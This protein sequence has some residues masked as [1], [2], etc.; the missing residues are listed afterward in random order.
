MRTQQSH[1]LG[2]RKQSKLIVMDNNNNNYVNNNILAIDNHGA[3][4]S[5][6]TLS[7]QKKKKSNYLF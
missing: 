5:F 7:M 3:L 1:K 6:V 2:S 4:G